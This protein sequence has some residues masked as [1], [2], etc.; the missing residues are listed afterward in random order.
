MQLGTLY[1]KTLLLKKFY[2]HNLMRHYLKYFNRAEN[3][4][5]N[6]IGSSCKPCPKPTSIWAP[7]EPSMKLK[8]I[9]ASGIS[10]NPSLFPQKATTSSPAVNLFNQVK[11]A[12]S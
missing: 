12:T 2:A 6:I 1:I 10:S 8:I 5:K 3:G 9:S 4:R 11:Q 7:I